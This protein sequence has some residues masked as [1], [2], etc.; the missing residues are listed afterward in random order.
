[1]KKLL[2]PIFAL[3]L[4]VGCAKTEPKQEEKP[5]VVKS[6]V[7]VEQPE[8]IEEE[9]DFPV[10]EEVVVVEEVSV[11]ESVEEVKPVAKPTYKKPAPKKKTTPKSVTPIPEPSED[12]ID[13]AI[14]EKVEEKVKIDEEATKKVDEI[15][16]PVVPEEGVEEE[17]GSK[18]IIIALGAVAA[19]VA[20]FVVSKM[21]KTPKEE[22]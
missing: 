14:V 19:A 9:P 5:E 20:A 15:E 12:E 1:M 18:G 4:I 7:V 10:E 17:K 3:L 21:K 8:V 11:E 13:T 6:T 22:E 16:P 2:M